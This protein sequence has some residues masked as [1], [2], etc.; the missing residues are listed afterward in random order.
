MDLEKSVQ[1]KV[2]YVD[3][4]IEELITCDLYREGSLE[5]R[6]KMSSMMLSQLKKEGYIAH[7]SYSSTDGLFSFQY[8]DGTLGGIKIEDF[9]SNPSDL[10]IN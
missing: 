2:D 3:E 4:K 10:P 9:N 1:D 8:A 5:E 6:E 7:L